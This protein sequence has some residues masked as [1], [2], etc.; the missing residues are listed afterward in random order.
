M[1][2]LPA[3]RPVKHAPFRHLC[4]THKRLP[5][6]NTI[7]HIPKVIVP[8]FKFIRYCHTDNRPRSQDL[9]LLLL[10]LVGQKGGA[11]GVLKDFADAVVGFGGAF[12]VFVGADLLADVLGL[13]ECY[14][15][16][17][18]RGVRRKR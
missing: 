15:S 7:D 12:E 13:R 5:S 8:D 16:M 17:E 3:C 14:V 18:V 9:A 4:H 6:H 10:G 1:N 2:S 11:R